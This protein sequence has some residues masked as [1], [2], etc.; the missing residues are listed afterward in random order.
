[1]VSKSQVLLPNTLFKSTV[2]SLGFWAHCASLYVSSTSLHLS[3]HT[4]LV[5]CQHAIGRRFY[6]NTFVHGQMWVDE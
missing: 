4:Y 1:M 5:A 6:I 2:F 3:S